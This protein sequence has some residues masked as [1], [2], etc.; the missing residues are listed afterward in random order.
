VSDMS[1]AQDGASGQRLL[2]AVVIGLGALIVIAL[3]FV[4]FGMVA[5]FQ[6]LGR[7]AAADAQSSSQV[8][9]LPKGARIVEMQT[10]SSRL[11]LRLRTAQGEEIDVVDTEDGHLVARIR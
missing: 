2:K 5:K 8:F 7:P 1:P 10:A 11:I 4:A 9:S 6:R 3:A